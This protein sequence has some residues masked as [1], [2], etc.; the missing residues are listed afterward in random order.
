MA[1]GGLDFYTEQKGRDWYDNVMAI[2]EYE[3]PAGPVRAFY[4]VLNTTSYGGFYETFMG[5]DGTLVISEDPRRGNIFREQAA[6]KKNWENEADKIESQNGD[7]IVLQLG[8]TLRSD[9]TPDPEGER[10]A[11]EAQKPPHQLHLENFFAAIREGVP[12]NCP[13]EVG[14]E[15]CVTVLKANEAV[16]KGTR[17]EFKGEEFKA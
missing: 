15:V 4:Q 2:Y 11:A 13:P 10:L 3:T 17:I 7:S 12:L 1:S 9:G 16:A 5:H 6:A 8:K 14:F